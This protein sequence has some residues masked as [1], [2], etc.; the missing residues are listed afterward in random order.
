MGFL[1]VSILWYSV[2]IMKGKFILLLCGLVLLSGCREPRQKVEEQEQ[3]VE[4]QATVPGLTGCKACHADVRPDRDHDLEC[5]V[6]HRGDAEAAEQEAAH[7]G[8]IERPAHPD[9]MTQTCGSCHPEQTEHIGDSLHFTL[10]NKVNLIRKHFGAEDTVEGLTRVPIVEGRPDTVR[11]LT[12]DMLRRRCLRCHVYSV[13]DTYPYTQRA[14]GCGACH[15]SVIDG[16]LIS[17]EI[18]GTPGDMQCMSCHYGNFV[19]A[20]YYGRFQSDFNLEYRTPYT[21]SEP[22]AR[23]YGVEYL[24]LAP[25]IHRRAGIACVDCHGGH[26]LM[27]GLPEAEVTCRGCHLQDPG[28]EEKNLPEGVAVEGGRLVLTARSSGEKFIIPPAVHPAHAEYGDTVACQVCHA[29]WTF[30]DNT[31]HLL[32]SDMDDYY[33]WERLMVQS[34]SE[35]EALLEHNI[36]SDEDELDP[37]MHD[38]IT[39]RPMYGLWFKGYTERRWERIKT[40]RDSDGMIRIFRPILDLRVSYINDDEQVVFD[41]VTGSGPALLPYTP[42]TTGPAGL[43]YLDR[44]LHLLQDEPVETT[45]EK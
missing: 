44:F 26:Q 12:D 17:H 8:L 32:R 39:G 45:S 11:E 36:Y 6:C 21:T 34:S 33:Q 42:H 10:S 19:G 14:A 15:M 16:R 28:E 9:I 41:N 35:I 7:A 30:T 20:D 18:I 22:F 4:R 5:T 38:T 1:D 29:Q 23:P 40:G 24:E 31:T 13:G 25:D 43:L 37:I 2:K 27:F 3:E